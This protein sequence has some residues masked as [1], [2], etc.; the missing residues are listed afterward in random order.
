MLYLGL[1]AG[2]FAGNAVA[3]AAGVDPFRVFVATLILIV[4][5]LIGARL[6]H[7]ASNWKVYRRNPGRIWDRREGGMAMLGGLPLALVLSLPLLSVLQLGLGAFWDVAIFTILTGIIFTRAGCL[8]NGCCAGRPTKSWLGLNLPNRRGAWERRLPTQC[9]EAAWALI[10]LASAFAV[11]S[12]MP[13][14][15]ALF[16]WIILGYSAGRL[17]LE[18]T[19]EPEPGRRITSGHTISVISIVICSVVLIAR[20]PK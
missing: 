3:H 13:F 19:R 17:M 11:R 2:V 8:L 5:A 4:P 18:W 6:L 16:L 14:S 1:V 15:G 9:L 12:R 7:V 20:W 10:L